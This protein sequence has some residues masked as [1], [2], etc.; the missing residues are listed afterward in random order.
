MVNY[1]ISDKNGS[2]IN[3]IV[4]D[5]LNSWNLPDGYLLHQEI[6]TPYEIGGKFIGDVYTPPATNIANPPPKVD[7][8]DSWDLV[9]LKIAFNHENRIRVLEGKPAVT[10]AQ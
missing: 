3:R 9:S 7:P 1:A 8:I 5:D 2:I 4:L 10:I 6:G